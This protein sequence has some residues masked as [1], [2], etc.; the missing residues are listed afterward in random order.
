MLADGSTG[1]RIVPVFNRLDHQVIFEAQQD[2][3]VAVGSMT[4]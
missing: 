4:L 1:V 2:W 3:Q